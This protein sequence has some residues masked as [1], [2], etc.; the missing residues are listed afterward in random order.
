[1]DNDSARLIIALQKEDLAQLE[2]LGNFDK[3]VI[4]AQREQ[5]EIDSRFDNVAF[6]S[7]RRLAISMSRAVQEDS[8]VLARTTR[9]RQPDDAS[10]QRFAAL[11]QIPPTPTDEVCS[12]LDLTQVRTSDSS[13]TLQ[14][15]LHAMSDN[16]HDPNT[17]L[18][19]KRA[20]TEEDDHDSGPA[21]KRKH[22]GSEDTRVELPPTLPQDV[23]QT[24]ALATVDDSS[25]DPSLKR[26]RADSQ[27]TTIE[28]NTHD[29]K[30]QHLIEAGEASSL[31]EYSISVPA[32]ATT[33]VGPA[34]P[35]AVECISCESHDVDD[36]IEV[37][38]G[39]HYCH[40][41]F[42]NF[43]AASLQAHDGYP[44][45]CCR[46]VFT[47]KTVSENVSAQLSSLY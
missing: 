44:P 3:A 4:D 45:K 15:P 35:P 32:V 21:L 20:V 30:R 41:C 38:C 42:E 12:T 31:V 36:L 9:V 46:I 26:K 25:S 43:V 28:S 1:M 17:G 10:F 23:P 11:N 8:A 18:K 34:N 16:G 13:L 5:L 47:H 39:H 14:P 37:L 40:E 22:A 7:S 27:E 6:E 24:I 2:A 29:Q 33:S 19:R